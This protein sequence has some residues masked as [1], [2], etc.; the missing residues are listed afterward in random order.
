[1][2]KCL[3]YLILIF[4]ITITKPYAY[5]DEYSGEEIIVTLKVNYEDLDVLSTVIKTPAGKFLI[6]LDDAKFFNLKDEYITSSVIEI[7][8]KKY[9]NLGNLTQI[10]TKYN[11]E[12]LALELDIPPEMVKLQN[13]DTLPRNSYK[14]IVGVNTH[15]AFMNYDLTLT[16]SDNTKYMSGLQDFNYFS[17][18]GILYY[19]FFLRGGIPNAGL[20]KE[21]RQKKVDK[22]TLRLESNWTFDNVDDMARWRVGDSIT[23]G[24]DWSGSTRFAGVQYST[25]FSTKPDLITHPLINFAGRSELP[26]TLDVY[27]NANQVYQTQSKTGDFELNSL[28]VPIGRGEVVI[29]AQD[30]TGKI[31]TFILPF[32]ITPNLLA[33]GLSDYSFETGM[34]REYFGVKS[35]KYKN[36]V[37]NGDY[38]WGV[39]DN[40]T[41]GM[42]FESLKNKA[43]TGV[44]NFFQIGNLGLVTASLGTNIHHLNSSQKAI[45]GYSYQRDVFSFNCSVT[46]ISKKY[47][48]IYNY[49][50]KTSTGTNYQTSF[51]YTN[52]KLGNI[53]L[54][55]LSYQ[56]A[57]SVN[58]SDKIEM[59]M[60][61]YDRQITKNSTLRFSVGTDLKSRNKSAFAYLSFNAILGNKSIGLSNSI[62]KGKAIQ[63]VSLSSQ[64]NTPLGWGYRANLGKSDKYNYDIQLNKNTEYVE[65]ALYLFDSDGGKTEQL[66]LAGSMVIMDKGFYLI[67]P[68]Y[69][70]LALVKVGKL[71]N[72]PVYNNNL[73]VGY[74]NSD[75]KVLIPNVLSYVPSEIKL[76][77]RKLPLDTN[78]ASTVLRTAPK[79]KSGVI[80]DFEVTRV[81]SVQMTL[82]SP[83]RKLIPFDEEVTV[84]GVADELFVGYD[85][86]LYINDIGNLKTLNGKICDNSQCCYFEKPIEEDAKAPII[87]LGEVI[88]Q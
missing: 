68:I 26:T 72:I 12:N 83:D 47:E 11:D 42:H 75:G 14:D 63:R 70:S 36:V 86:I 25:N 27:I 33:K 10:T 13:F 74:T 82:L 7:S 84:E 6:P 77:Q 30:I 54:N 34:Q 76:D 37:S 17:E 88:C 49:P 50:A 32:Y 66:G 16:H 71:K 58:S 51:G 67:R 41:S 8:G 55:F 2:V 44:S 38:K 5:A 80:I 85:G 57:N 64:P 78:F 19:S 52:K 28:P 39:T 65:S 60:A 35:N 23:K 20:L 62:Q 56:P 53:Y 22:E 24:A 79:W 3:S 46:K 9:I 1:M 40:W 4:L 69:D 21:K 81:K 45:L 48:D 18:N 29:K 61:N 15:G 43:S 73:K 59:V 87:D 31:K